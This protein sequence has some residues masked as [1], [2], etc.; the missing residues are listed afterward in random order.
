MRFIEQFKGIIESVIVQNELNFV[1]NQYVKKPFINYFGVNYND[2]NLVSVKLYF[3]FFQY[4]SD[5]M[6]ERFNVSNEDLVLIRE[7]WMP[8]E[9]YDYMHQGLTFGLKCYLKDGEIKVNKYFH[10]RSPIKKQ[11]KPNFIKITDVEP[12]NH[13]GFCVE[14]NFTNKERKNYYYYSTK[15]NLEVLLSEFGLA[16]EEASKI[17]LIEYTESNIEKK[18][19]IIYNKAE[20]ILNY[21]KNSKNQNIVQFNKYLFDKYGLYFFGPGL[22]YKSS[23]KAI[24]YVTKNSFYGLHEEQTLKLFLN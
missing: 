24:Y 18:I 23:T 15:A 9:S 8:S 20:D 11:V 7:N 16:K 17:S 10:F 14:Y 3:S 13:P 1:L 22:R 12:D 2:D 6:F 21:L 5:E 19:N 4:P